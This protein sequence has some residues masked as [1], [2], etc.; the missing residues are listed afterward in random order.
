MLGGHV[1]DDD[2]LDPFRR[3]DRTPTCDRQTERQ[4]D[5]HVDDDDL[6]DLLDDEM[7]FRHQHDDS[8]SVA[9][10]ACFSCKPYLLLL[11]VVFRH[12]LTLSFHA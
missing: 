5:R 10:T 11:L 3:F 12:P 6:D 2:P 4:T 7:D 9:R 8:T 1:D